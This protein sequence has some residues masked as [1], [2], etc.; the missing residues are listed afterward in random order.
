MVSSIQFTIGVFIRL[1]LFSK[2]S[3]NNEKPCHFRRISKSKLDKI[4]LNH[5]IKM[6]ISEWKSK[7]FAWHT[8]LKGKK[9]K[10]ERKNSH[11]KCST[12][13]VIL[14]NYHR[15]KF[16]YWLLRLTGTWI[17]FQLG[18]SWFERVSFLF[19]FFS[20]TVTNWNVK[21]STFIRREKNLL[22]N[23]E[24][25]GFSHCTNGLSPHSK[26]IICSLNR[27]AINQAKKEIRGKW[28]F[29]ALLT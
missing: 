11:V 4:I 29:T 3:N 23:I 1:K 26:Q 27:E 14:W 18:C 7:W 24:W 20:K 5:E 6:S 12:A 21:P 28:V 16:R 10:I 8:K 9:H 15:S 17:F 13:W 22:L 2:L 19:A 25:N